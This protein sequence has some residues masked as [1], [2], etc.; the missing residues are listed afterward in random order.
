MCI[1]SNFRCPVKEI[2]LA[3][4][5]ENG[6]LVDEDVMSFKSQS[7]NKQEVGSDGSFQ[8]NIQLLW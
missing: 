2:I 7:Q 8:G 4:A 3:A 1:C 5:V 6:W